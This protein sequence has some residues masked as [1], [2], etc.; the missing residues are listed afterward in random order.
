MKTYTDEYL[1][2]YADRYMADGISDQ[3]VSLEVYLRS[4][5]RY[6]KANKQP[7]PIV[8]MVAPTEKLRH[9]RYKRNILNARFRPQ[10]K[11]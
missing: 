2:H 4:P 11:A 7:T 1:N 3:G 8:D 6:A 10:A 5:Q 9:K